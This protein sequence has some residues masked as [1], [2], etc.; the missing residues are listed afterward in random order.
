MPGTIASPQKT[1]PFFLGSPVGQQHLLLD[2]SNW[3]NSRRN[4]K[5]SGGGPK[6]TTLELAIYQA[7]RFDF[8]FAKAALLGLV[9]LGVSALAAV[10]ALG[11][12]WGHQLGIGLDRPIA[13]GRHS[14]LQKYLDGVVIGAALLFLGLPLLLVLGNGR[15]SVTSLPAAVWM[16]ALRS[17]L[18]ALGATALCMLLSLSL[19]NRSGEAIATLGITVSPLVLGTGW[20]ANRQTN[21]DPMHFAAR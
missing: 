12:A 15:G 19:L 7:F 3:R 6:S 9:Q 8:D 17:V 16:A 14:T 13:L 4:G 11:F 2:H 1:K 21:G 18:I 5:F 10:F 20:V